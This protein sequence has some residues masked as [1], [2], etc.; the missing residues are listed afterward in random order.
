MPKKQ[1][2]V[3]LRL[4][5]EDT[6][7]NDES[8]SITAQRGI[9]TQFIQG[10]PELASMKTVE[11]VD[12]GYSGTNFDRP[13]FKRMMAMVR[14]G[15]V[16]CIVVK[17]LS[18]FARNYI[19]AGDYLEHIF[20]YLGIRFIAVNNH[21]D[22]DQFIGTTG[23]IDVAF[24][25]FMYEMYSVDISKKVKASQHMLMRSGRYVS[26]CPYGYT[27]VKGQKHHMVPDPETAPIVRDIFLCQTDTLKIAFSQAHY[28]MDCN[29]FINW[30][31][32]NSGEGR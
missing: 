14:S 21:Y 2:A 18:R 20:P 29:R 23:G 12:D 3:Y 25:N 8:N 4:S 1:L 16:S 27:K 17:D 26:H 30:M 5:L 10:Q 22:S 31:Q 24:R 6:G 11:F 19:E 28:M 13:G 7:A 15:D 32:M 9:T